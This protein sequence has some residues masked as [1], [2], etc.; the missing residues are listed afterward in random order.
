MMH[1]PNGQRVT[2]MSGTNLSGAATEP[3]AQND[4]AGTAEV[5]LDSATLKRLLSEVRNEESID[6]A[7]YN[8]THNRHNRT[9]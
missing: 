7:S 1:H 3:S 5:E 4:E 2:I 9:R 6:P 8:R